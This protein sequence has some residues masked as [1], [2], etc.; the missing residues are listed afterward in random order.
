M[1]FAIN[2]KIFLVCCIWVKPLDE[3]W[4]FP[5]FAGA[6][7]VRC[8]SDLRQRSVSR[9]AAVSRLGDHQQ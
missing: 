4:N 2:F 7:D 6:A 3:F 5:L 9:Q 8:P 1:L